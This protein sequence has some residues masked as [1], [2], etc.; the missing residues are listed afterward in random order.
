MKIALLGY[1]KMGKAIEEIALERG[2]EVVLKITSAN[3]DSLTNGD[4][5]KADVAIEFTKPDSA[6]TN[7]LSCFTHDLPVVCGTTGW[8]ARLKDVK[9]EC[10]AKQQALLYASN[11]SIGVNLFFA[12]NN[13]AAQL[14]S[15]QPSYSASVEEIH[16][17]HKLDA[18]SG[19]AITIAE[20]MLNEYKAFT[21]WTLVEKEK[22]NENENENEKQNK[23]PITAIRTDEVP[24]THTVYYASEIDTIEL[25]HT[26]HSRKGFA[27]GAVVAAEWLHGKKGCFTMQHVLNLPTPHGSI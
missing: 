22:E 11:F 26:A 18:P 3:R 19:T 6:V 17:V 23:L 21:G 9:D 27:L 13:Y 7:I 15:K 1:G 2:H 25:K 24:G 4:L 5:K 8:N 14:F 20:G 10:N 12:L 16:H